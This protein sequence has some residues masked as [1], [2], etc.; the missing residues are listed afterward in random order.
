MVTTMNYGFFGLLWRLSLAGV[1]VFA[2]AGAGGYFAVERMLHVEEAL[3]PDLLM[4]PITEALD[5]AS[6]AGFPVI[7]EGRERSNLVPEGAVL[8]Q[9]PGPGTWMKSGA[10]IR[11]TLARER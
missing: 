1:V 10:T 11:V 4:L 9:R 2:L 8:S 5:K 7:L 3:A 6:G